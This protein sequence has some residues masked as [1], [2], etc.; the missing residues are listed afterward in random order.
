MAYFEKGMNGFERVCRVAVDIVFTLFVFLVVFILF[1]T[2]GG[3]TFAAAFAALDWVRR[4]VDVAQLIHPKAVAALK[5][6][7]FPQ[8]IK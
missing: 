2:W 8:E 4:I 3:V 5:L 7:V 1:G 6:L